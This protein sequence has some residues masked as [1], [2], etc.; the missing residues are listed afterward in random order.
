M[1]D[2]PDSPLIVHDSPLIHYFSL[3][4]TAPDAMMLSTPVAS[5]QHAQQAQL[6]R[7]ASRVDGPGDDEIAT[8]RGKEAPVGCTHHLCQLG[9]CGP[10]HVFF[11]CPHGEILGKS[12][13]LG[14]LGPKSHAPVCIPSSFPRLER[15][16]SNLRSTR[17]DHV[18]NSHPIC[19]YWP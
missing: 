17:I 9:R 7:V 14:F 12:D 18:L 5:A 8:L 13:C 4:F 2:S 16:L 11:S 19:Q 3:F 6:H 15:R 1:G 10:K